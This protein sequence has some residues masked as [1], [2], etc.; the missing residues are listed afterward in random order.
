MEW[1]NGRRPGEMRG[2]E[3][4]RDHYLAAVAKDPAVEIT[5]AGAGNTEVGPGPLKFPVLPG[6]VPTERMLPGLVGIASK[7][8]S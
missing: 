2:A 6:T 1:R 3:A 7:L 5:L 4:V 8:N